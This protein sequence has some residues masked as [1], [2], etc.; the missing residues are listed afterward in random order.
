MRQL[1]LWRVYFVQSIVNLQVWNQNIIWQCCEPIKR[2]LIMTT[3]MA[4]IC[5]QP[6]YIIIGPPFKPMME[7]CPWYRIKMI[8]INRMNFWAHSQLLWDLMHEHCI[9]GLLLLIL[10]HSQ[11]IAWVYTISSV[12][13]FSLLFT[14]FSL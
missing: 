11:Y 8:D 2:V 7:C 6:K 9:Y 5:L 4:C 12:L 1:S 3:C 10:F 13:V 14:S